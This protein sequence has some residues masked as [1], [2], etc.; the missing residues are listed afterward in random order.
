M[1]G[2]LTYEQQLLADVTA[3]E[4]A[5][6]QGSTTPSTISGFLSSPIFLIGGGLLAW[7]LITRK[8]HQSFL[9]HKARRTR[10]RR[11]Y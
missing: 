5:Q 8:S 4:V 3:S 7:Y 2:Q 1:I 9:P 6:T 11:R 10:K